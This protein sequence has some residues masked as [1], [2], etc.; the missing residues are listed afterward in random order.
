MKKLSFILFLIGSILAFNSCNDDEVDFN[1]YG[2]VIVLSRY[3]ETDE[4][5]FAAAYYAYGNKSMENVTVITP[6]GNN[7]ELEPYNEYITSSFKKEPTDENYSPNLPLSGVYQFVISTTSNETDSVSD[8]VESEN[9]V[10]PVKINDVSFTDNTLSAE[11]D[12]VPNADAYGIR[13]VNLSDPETIYFSSGWFSETSF[14]LSYV[15]SQI[16]NPLQSG[17][18]VIIEI[19]ACKFEDVVGD[20]YNFE[21]ISSS[22]TT[23]IWE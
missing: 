10:Y 15:N 17:E 21:S 19:L 4:L 1:A 3:L 13:I 8:I 23:L 6:D 12:E 18:E 9:F 20:I 5:E 11:W 16:T 2:D 7:I 14:E 22:R